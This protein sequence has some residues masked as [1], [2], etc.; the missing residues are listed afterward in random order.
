MAAIAAV[1][2]RRWT[3]WLQR[4]AGD[5]PS[6]SAFSV[7]A[8]E[9]DPQAVDL[10]AEVGEERR[11]QRDRGEHHDQ[12]GEGGRE[13]DAVHV[14]Q[15]GQGEAEDGDHDGG[16]G[17][18]H[19]APR[20]GDGLDDGVVAVLALLHRRPEPGQDEQRVIDADPD[21]DQPG[22]RRGPVGDVDDVGEQDDQA[23]GRDAEADE[24]DRERQA[25]GD[26]RA[27]GDQQHDRGPEEP[28]PLRAARLL[29]LVDRIPA[30]LDLQPVAAVLL[31]CGDQLLAVLLVDVPAVGRQ[32]ENGRSDRAVLRVPD[33]GDVLGDVIDLLG[34]GEEGVDALPGGGAVGAGLVLPDDV[35]LL[36]GVAV[37]PLLGELARRLRLRARRVVVGLVLPGQRGAHADDHDR[38]RDPGEDHAAAAAVG[39]VGKTG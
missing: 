35:D 3:A 31:G 28:D 30:E 7:P 26:H 34:L 36:A 15:A 17:D 2:G 16:A 5:S 39:E 33:R 32:R 24:G 9:G 29:R 10:R 1:Q 8:E 27:E 6:P 22:H 23:P 4:A 14:G 20:G 11:Q 12:D 38:R 19:A 13:G 37:E 25:G 18:D 21:P